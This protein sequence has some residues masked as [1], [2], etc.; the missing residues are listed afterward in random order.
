VPT[1]KKMDW[2]RLEHWRKSSNGAKSTVLEL[3]QTG[4]KIQQE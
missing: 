4:A 3:A 1:V 2:R